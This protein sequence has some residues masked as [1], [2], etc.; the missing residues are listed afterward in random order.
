LRRVKGNAI[1]RYRRR[2]AAFLIPS[3]RCPHISSLTGIPCT[4]RAARSADTLCAGN[5]IDSISPCFTLKVHFRQDRCAACGQAI[6]RSAEFDTAAISGVSEV[7]DMAKKG[8]SKTSSG[9]GGG[10]ESSTGLVVSLVV[11]ILLTIGLGVTTYLGY[12]GQEEFKKQAKDASD[13]AAAADKKARSEEAQKLALRNALG[14]AEPADKTAFSAI[15]SS[16]GEGLSAQIAKISDNLTVLLRDLSSNEALAA[17]A[18]KLKEMSTTRWDPTSDA[19]PKTYLG[20]ITDLRDA[21]K[22]QVARGQANSVASNE[23]K[24]L[25]TKRIQELDGKLQESQTALKKSHDDLV[26]L[27]N[28]KSDTSTSQSA[29]INSLSQQSAQVT[30]EKDNLNAEKS[31]EIKRLSIQ[32]DSMN[33]VR[34]NFKSRVG[35]ILEKLGRIKLERPE[36]RELAEL[37][38]LLL[39]QFESAISIAND[40]P[41]GSIVRMDRV[42]NL[43]YVNLGRAD[44]IRPGVTFAVLPA[45]STGRAAAARERKGAVEVVDVL[46]D[47][48]STAKVLEATNATRDPLL[49]GDL[50]FNP[51]WNSSQR[52]HVAIAGIVDLNGDGIDD[53]QDL[54]RML[55]RQGVVVDAYLDLKERTIKGPGITEKTTYLILGE[56]PVLSS[57]VQLD[58]NPLTQAA[59][60][61]NG[62]MEEMKNKARELGAQ[63]TPYRRFLLLMGFKLPKIVDSGDISASNYLR[64]IQTKGKTETSEDKPK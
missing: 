20:L 54:I 49:P 31:A 62:K 48:L 64:G 1:S 8:G 60:D 6:P 45:G 13:K 5:P 41:K 63:Q 28:E 51:A 30:N 25:L 2:G 19:P 24:E 12:A 53:T 46:E 43:A 3:F 36:I 40:T 14:I 11:F 27:Q 33:K 10:G 44:F 61:I 38:E 17:L 39:K 35:P 55:E 42:N 4:T 37:H 56:K 26:R 50:L 57:T 18:P 59:L 9:G 22:A 16:G 47:H 29:K 32:I 34:E 58:N 21:F 23:E 15:K 52:E 7:G